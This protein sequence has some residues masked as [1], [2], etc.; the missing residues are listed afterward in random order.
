MS[1]KVTALLSIILTAEGFILDG[2][3]VT[4]FRTSEHTGNK[5]NNS[6]DIV[7]ELFLFEVFSDVSKPDLAITIQDLEAAGIGKNKLDLVLNKNDRKY[8]LNMYS[9][10]CVPWEAPDILIL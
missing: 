4:D 5:P 3:P 9:K 7:L 2:D 1:P 10:A 8:V 6:E